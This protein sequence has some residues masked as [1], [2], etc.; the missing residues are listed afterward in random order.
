MAHDFKDTINLPI[1]IPVWGAICLVGI[2]IFTA[3]TLYQQMGTLIDNNRASDARIASMHERQIIS[4][5]AIVTLERQV[6]T[7]EARMSNIDARMSG[8]ERG[9]FQEKRLR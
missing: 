2:G 8:L 9:Q 3:G 7:V 6:S 1:A 4:N 5:A